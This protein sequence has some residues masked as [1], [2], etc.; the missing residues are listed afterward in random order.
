M[1]LGLLSAVPEL[2]KCWYTCR[3]LELVRSHSRLIPCKPDGSLCTA[4]ANA[5][6]QMHQCPPG[7]TTLLRSLA[8]FSALDF[9][10]VSDIFTHTSW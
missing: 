4:L 7:C 9:R 1:P 2:M 10:N 3:S 8:S 6:A 5:H